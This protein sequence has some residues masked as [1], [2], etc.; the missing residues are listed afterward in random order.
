MQTNQL[1]PG[2][3]TDLVIGN[4]TLLDNAGLTEA[5]PIAAKNLTAWLQALRDGIKG[6]F[7]APR[8]TSVPFTL[9]AADWDENK[10]QTVS[11]TGVK[12]ASNGVVLPDHAITQ[13]QADALNAASCLLTDQEADAITVTC[14]GSVP[15]VDIPMFMLLL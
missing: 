3:V 8:S 1:A 5:P 14:F 12:L 6:A 7:K 4:R 10:T 2:E 13:E 11:V 9:A 15:T